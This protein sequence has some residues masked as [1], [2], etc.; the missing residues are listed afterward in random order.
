MVFLVHV[1][2]PFFSEIKLNKGLYE[3][4]NISSVLRILI[5]IF[6]FKYFICSVL[7]IQKQENYAE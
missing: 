6:I 4:N 7:T 1:C 5:L 2:P 3:T